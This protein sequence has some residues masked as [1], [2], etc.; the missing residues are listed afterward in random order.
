[1][2][3]MDDL[4]ERKATLRT[5]LVTRRAALSAGDRTVA[6]AAACANLVDLVRA[7]GDRSVA[8]F[9][10]MRGELDPRGAAAHLRSN[11]CT[12]VY[13]R[14]VG[15]RRLAFHVTA[16]EELLRPSPLG[17]AEPDASWPEVGMAELG[18]IV[19]PGLAFDRDGGRLGW[20]GGYYDATLAFPSGGLRVG[21]LH[22]LQLVDT[23]PRGPTDQLVDVLVDE[24]GTWPTGRGAGS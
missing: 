5:E 11:G 6:A 14:V 19:I 24:R 4:V 15:R 2:A 13:P 7:R 20:G 21:F 22:S 9:A 17:I 8:L 18:V 3:N 10:G 12:V 23:V 1:M 16:A